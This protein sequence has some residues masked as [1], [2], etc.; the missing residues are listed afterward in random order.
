[1]STT[2]EQKLKLLEWL[3]SIQDEGLL[4]ELMEW[5]KEHLRINQHQYNQELAEANTRIEA[6]EY[7]SHS[8]VVRESETWLK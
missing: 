1:M 2:D 6:G 3:A 4:M 7:A 5:K 8:D